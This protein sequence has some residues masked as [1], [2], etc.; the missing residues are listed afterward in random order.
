MCAA[1]ALLVAGLAAGCGAH[2]G[3]HVPPEVQKS[4]PVDYSLGNLCPG[5]ETS[6]AL[7][8]RIAATADALI[9]ELHRRPDD[10]VTYTFEYEDADSQTRDITVRELA[11]E[12]LGDLDCDPRLKRRIQAAMR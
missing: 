12:Q 4:L 11:R 2:R 9:R 1:I 7:A 8:R 3:A 5:A 6:P 10:L